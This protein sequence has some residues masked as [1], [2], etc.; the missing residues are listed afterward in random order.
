MDAH[1]KVAGP[2]G[3]TAEWDAVITEQIPNRV[4]AWES[5]EGSPVK[6]Q[7]RVQFLE[8]RN[9]GTRIS[10]RMAYTPPAGALGHAV[11]AILGKDP[12]HQMD[13]DLA[14][15]KSLMETGETTVKDRKVTDQDLPESAAAM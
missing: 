9:G 2:A 8:N 6:T 14:L 7:G 15:L 11:V 5:V 10:V 12:K 4:I 1:T 13:Q 3:S